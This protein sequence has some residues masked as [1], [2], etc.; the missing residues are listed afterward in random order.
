[1]IPVFYTSPENIEADSLI[2]A[3]EEGHH[4]K[5]VFRLTRGETIMAVDGIGNGYRCEI[6]TI[7]PRE[8]ACKIISRT[9]NWGEPMHHLTLAAGLS[10]GYKFDDVI[11]RGTELGVSRFV[12]LIT[13][14]SIVRAGDDGGKSNKLARW[15]KV[16][17]ASVKQTG[18]SVIPAIEPAVDFEQF[19]EKNIKPGRLIMFDT[20]EG[21]RPLDSLVISS[22]DKEYTILVGPESGFSRSEIELAREKGAVV[23]SLGKRVL[24]TENAG[25]TAVALLMNLL[26]EFK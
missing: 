8:I 4:L 11:Q 16:A 3:G 13:G 22:E 12:P 26:G 6:D 23:L 9:R 10:T 15:Q 1:M 21:S 17:L 2:I 25:P 20:G 5:N 18:R 24:R 14:K 7:S 19:M